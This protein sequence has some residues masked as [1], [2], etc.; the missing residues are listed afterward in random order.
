MGERDVTNLGVLEIHLS[1]GCKSQAEHWVPSTYLF[2]FCGPDRRNNDVLE[3][4]FH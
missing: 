1:Q 4:L 2:L 3:M